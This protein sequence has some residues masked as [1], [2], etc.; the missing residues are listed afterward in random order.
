MVSANKGHANPCC[1]DLWWGEVI[2]QRTA[3]CP[4]Q[5]FALVVMHR[6]EH[7]RGARRPLLPSNAVERGLRISMPPLRHMPSRSMR[8]SSRLTWNHMLRVPGLRV[9]DWSQS[10]Q[11][12]PKSMGWIHCDSD[13]F[14]GLLE[15]ALRSAQY[16]CACVPLSLV[17][18]SVSA[19]ALHLRSVVGAE[20]SSSF[21]GGG[22]PRLCLD[23]P[24]PT[25]TCGRSL[26]SRTALAG[27]ASPVSPAPSRCRT[28]PRDCRSREPWCRLVACPSSRNRIQPSQSSP[29]D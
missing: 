16:G 8:R 3:P 11:I 19:A 20:S 6:G 9:E 10:A 24:R 14:L 4:A 25:V 12:V 18:S 21:A 23:R 29:V 13:V 27:A 7:R 2:K 5:V 26:L 22:T 1:R 17:V 28:S 15:S